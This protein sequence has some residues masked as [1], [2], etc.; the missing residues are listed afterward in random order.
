MCLRRRRLY[1]AVPHRLQRTGA[2]QVPRLVVA[3]GHRAI[4]L[5]SRIAI[6]VVSVGYAAGLPAAEACL[7]V[8]QL[9]GRRC[10]GVG[11]GWDRHMLLVVAV[12]FPVEE[13]AGVVRV[14]FQEVGSVVAANDLEVARTG[15]VLRLVEAG[16]AV[17]VAGG[18]E[19][20]L[21][22]EGKIGLPVAAQSIVVAGLSHVSAGI[23]IVVLKRGALRRATYH[24]HLSQVVLL[25]VS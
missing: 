4:V 8:P 19:E 17:V 11:C 10:L 9:V 7:G 21:E 15:A 23:Y 3:A 14:C 22:A 13:R 6:V 1:L 25:P 2:E 24:N 5:R 16:S 12:A 18:R 20:R